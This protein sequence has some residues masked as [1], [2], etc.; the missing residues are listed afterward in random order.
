[1]KI[2]EVN[3]D[4]THH[5][6]N[7]FS[8]IVLYQSHLGTVRGIFDPMNKFT[9]YN[10]MTNEIHAYEVL[11]KRGREYIKLKYQNDPNI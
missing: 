8:D 2:P 1:M 9:W 3:I 4:F 5:Y 11:T 10:L 7:R 6:E